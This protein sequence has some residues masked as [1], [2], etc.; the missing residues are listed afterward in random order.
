M[1]QIKKMKYTGLTHDA[2]SQ[3]LP[4]SEINNFKG[5]GGQD[6]T[7]SKEDHIARAFASK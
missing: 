1:E 5:H 2:I 4:V 7:Q 6:V 3:K